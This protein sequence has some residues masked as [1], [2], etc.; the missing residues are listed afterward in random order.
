[1]ATILTKYK[2]VRKVLFYVAD[3][4]PVINPYTFEPQLRFMTQ[5][6]ESKVELEW[7]WINIERS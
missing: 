7:H 5:D 4:T 1:M 2:D 6:L 3:V